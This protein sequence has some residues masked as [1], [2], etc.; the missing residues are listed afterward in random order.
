[1]ILTKEKFRICLRYVTQL[2]CS[3]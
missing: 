2:A 3:R 1:M